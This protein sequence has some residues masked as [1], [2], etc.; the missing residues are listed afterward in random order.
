MK[1]LPELEKINWDFPGAWSTYGVHNF[2]WFPARL[3][4]QIP[5]IFITSLT[6]ESDAVLD[7]FCGSGSTLVE[8]LRLGRKAIGVDVLPLACLISKV[9][10]HIIEPKILEKSTSQFSGKL[11]KARLS[12]GP[13]EYVLMPKIIPASRLREV[14]KSD[15]RSQLEKW[16]HPRTYTE[17]QQIKRLID[18]QDDKNLRDFYTV[19]LSDRLKSCCSQKRHG[20]HWGYIADNVLPKW[21]TYINAFDQFERHLR[22]MVSGMKE[23]YEECLKLRVSAQDLQGYCEVHQTNTKKLSEIIKPESI[24]LVFTSPPYLHTIDYTTSSRLSAFML[25]YDVNSLKQKEIGARWKR[26]RRR[27]TDDYVKEMNECFY[28][29][30]AVMKRGA[31]FGVIFGRLR[32][33]KKRLAVKGLIETAKSDIGF[34][35]T[36]KLSRAITH[37]AI[38]A[39]SVTHEDIYI[40]RK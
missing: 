17:L 7:P 30:H 34:K 13:K 27:S 39:K 5:A 38:G 10:T 15:G 32:K 20:S 25:E 18:Q 23:L 11:R 9:K 16:F 35:E 24:D 14:S 2:H 26:N 31:F 37:Q 4:P 33:E 22:K 1:W 6:K 29:I 40:L 28:Q 36:K 19:C 3:I 21:L 8:A 12:H